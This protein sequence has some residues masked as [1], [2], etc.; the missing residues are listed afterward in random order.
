MAVLRHQHE[1]VQALLEFGFPFTLKNSR[2]WEPVDEAISLRDRAMVKLLIAADVAAFKAEQKAK[3]A[4]LLQTMRDLDDFTFKVQ[5]QKQAQLYSCRLSGCVILT[6]GLPAAE[7]GA[8]KPP[9]GL[10]PQEICPT[11]HI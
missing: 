4:A 10:D 7:M 8:G 6:S 1:L 11:R 2:R 5:A 9:V 3:R